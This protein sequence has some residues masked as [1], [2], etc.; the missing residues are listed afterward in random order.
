MSY[1]DLSSLLKP[2]EYRPL[3][4]EDLERMPGMHH[5]RV[6][7]RPKSA[8]GVSKRQK[9]DSERTK[10]VASQTLKPKK[11]ARSSDCH[12]TVKEC[13]VCHK[14]YSVRF[15]SQASEKADYVCRKCLADT[16]E[17]A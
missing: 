8:T 14:K 9:P 10:K 15:K 16:E 5:T 3:T 7:K 1:S 13:G 17:K 2:Q 6:E 11:T 4:I 12:R